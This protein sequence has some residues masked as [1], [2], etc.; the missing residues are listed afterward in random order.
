MSGCHVLAEFSVYLIGDFAL[1]VFLFVVIEYVSS[2]RCYFM[3][4]FQLSSNALLA[5]H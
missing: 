5:L 3:R 1:L 2:I 4:L